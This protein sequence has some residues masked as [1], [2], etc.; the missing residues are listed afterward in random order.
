MLPSNREDFI[1]RI[2]EDLGEPVIQVN[3]SRAQLENAVDDALDYWSRWHHHG[4]EVAYLAI[5]ITQEMLDKN[6]I[7]PLPENVYAVNDIVD[8]NSIG[9]ALGWMSFEYQ[10]TKDALYDTMGTSGGAGGMAMM[11]VAKQYLSDI[12]KLLRAPIRY[13]FST[14]RREVNVLDNMTRYYKPGSI[15]VLE[16]HGFLF[17]NDSYNIWKDKELRQLAI[18]YAKKIWGQNLKK[19]SGVSLPSGTTLNGESIYS[20]AIREIQE[21][22]E[23]IRSLGAPYGIIV[24]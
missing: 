2:K 21:A 24:E 14:Y 4:Q 22:E 1:Q 15:A 3:I 12:Q 13:D 11:T 16:V 7:G 19:F 10:F 18:A 23:F 6:V 5:E 9:G 17:Y 8:P 20:D